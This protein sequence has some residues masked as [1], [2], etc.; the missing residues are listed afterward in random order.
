MSGVLDTA[1]KKTL[2]ALAA[3]AF[4]YEIVALASGWE[5]ITEAMAELGCGRPWVA[6]WLAALLVHLFFPRRDN[7]RGALSWFLILSFS[8]TVAWEVSAIAFA[9]GSFFMAAWLCERLWLPALVGAIAGHLGFTRPILA[10]EK[11]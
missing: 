5:P 2:A 8:F 4:A 6:Y 11:G 3:V 9:P 1:T 10:R 7:P